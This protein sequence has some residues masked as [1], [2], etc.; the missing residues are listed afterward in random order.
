MHFEF[1]QPVRVG[2]LLLELD[3]GAAVRQHRAARVK[4]IEKRKALETVENWKN[5]TEMAGARRSLT[6]ARR[7]IEDQERRLKRTRFLLEQGLIAQSEHEDVE[8]QYQGQLLDFEATRE[9]FDAVL[10]GGG[11]EALDKASL[12]LRTAEE[13]MLE[14]EADLDKGSIRASLSGVVTASLGGLLPAVGRTVRKGD[15]LASIGDFTR[16]AATAQVDEIDVVRIAVGQAV[17]VTGNAFP[18]LMLEGVV[19]HVS[20]QPMQHGSGAARFDVRVLLDPLDEAKQRKLR[21]GMSGMLDIVIY[22]N[23]EALL[24][25]ITAMG[26]S[27]RIHYVQAIDPTT[28]ETVEREVKVGPTTMDSVEIVAG[29]AAGDAIAVPLH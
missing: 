3:V 29:L 18:G 13:R 11:E 20:S 23:D 25:P 10:A 1:G 8:R 4:Y 17:S 14:L 16:M 27:G 24:V 9:D 22:R 26:R 28:G 12:E 21:A 19:A 5:S 15:P 2:D 7:A 6:R